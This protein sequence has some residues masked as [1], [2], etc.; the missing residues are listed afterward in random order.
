MAGNKPLGRQKSTLG[1][2]AIAAQ[3]TSLSRQPAARRRSSARR[4]PAMKRLSKFTDV[5]STRE[6]SSPPPP[7]ESSEREFVW[8]HFDER[9]GAVGLQSR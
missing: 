3:S 4:R 1:S 8:C 9:S 7:V 2:R 5:T 6:R